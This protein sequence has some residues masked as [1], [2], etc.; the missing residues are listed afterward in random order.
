[1]TIG[2]FLTIAINKFFF[3]V[4]QPTKNKNKQNGPTIL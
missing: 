2:V 3:F 1:M 4:F